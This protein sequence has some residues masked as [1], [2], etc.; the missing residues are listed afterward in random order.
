MSQYQA[1]ALCAEGKSR[2][3]TRAPCAATLHSG[4]VSYSRLGTWG[5]GGEGVRTVESQMHFKVLLLAP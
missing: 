5:R 2:W 3:C 4:Q 1:I